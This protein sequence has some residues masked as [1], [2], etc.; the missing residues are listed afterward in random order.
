MDPKLRLAVEQALT[1]QKAGH[2]IMAEALYRLVLKKEPDHPGVLQL[3]GL[4]KYQNAKPK[5]ALELILRAIRLAGPVPDFLYNLGNVYRALEDWANA[6]A[7]YRQCLQGKPDYLQAIDNLALTLLDLGRP[8][9]AEQMLRY[10]VNAHPTRQAW[11]SFARLFHDQ[12]L[13]PQCAEALKRA[14]ALEPDNAA[15]HSNLIYTGYLNPRA[16]P[17]E[18][19]A[20]H[21]RFAGRQ[22]ALNP[23][24]AQPFHN[25]RDPEKRIRIGYISPDFRN[26]PVGQFL[27]PV[28]ANHD[29]SR[30]EIF[31]Y[32]EVRRPDAITARLKPNADV[33]RDLVDLGDAKTA[34][35]VRRDRVDVLVD[36]SGHT[37][38]TRLPLFLRR[39][40]PVQVSYLGQTATTGL[41]TVDYLITTELIHPSSMDPT[42]CTEKLLRVPGSFSAYVPPPNAPEVNALPALT[43]G[44]VTF[45]STNNPA[46]INDDVLALWARLLDS[47]P[48]AR[49]MMRVGQGAN[50][51]PMARRLQAHGIPPGKCVLVPPAPREQFLEIYHHADLFLDPFPYNGYTTT[52]ESLYMGVPVIT[53]AAKPLGP[54]RYGAH[55]VSTVGL[56]DLVAGSPEEY[57]QIAM[58]L[59]G[60][61]R[62]LAEIRSSLRGRMEAGPLMDAVSV[63]RGLEEAYR[64]AWRGWCA[65]QSGTRA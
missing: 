28:F 57:V 24:I 64:Q 44:Q 34:A 58:R 53:N 18:I 19:L 63:T 59:A 52:H 12:G 60:D 65:G 42:W 35:L 48:N 20:E 39:P 51:A 16:T 9:E 21:G 10:C 49:L 32:S 29:H 33:W 17:D 27:V 41:P 54:S 40:A 62:R 22:A 38:G 36:L 31:C 25:Q 56:G 45:L 43:T 46:K 14:H 37:T 7:A 55:L 3:L 4:L 13:V 5:E 15:V 47:I 30:F 50:N 6:E 61:L 8:D 11:V 26:H 23:V 2:R 1:A